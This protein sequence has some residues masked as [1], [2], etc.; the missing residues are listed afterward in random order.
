MAGKILSAEIE[1]RK[2]QQFHGISGER[3]VEL[4]GKALAGLSPME[5]L[6]FS[7]AG[8]MGIDVVHILGKMRTPP[9]SIKAYVE[10]TRAESEPRRFVR[11]TLKFEIRGTNVKGGDIERAIRLSR[12][13]YCSVYHTLRNDIEIETSYSLAS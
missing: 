8:C 6:L 7:L 10:G 2:E 5:L 4:D 13:K 9:E 1:W 3:A 12:E 11:I